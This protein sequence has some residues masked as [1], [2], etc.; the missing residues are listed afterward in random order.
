[1]AL[2]CAGTK[3]NPRLHGW[4]NS[5]RVSDVAWVV[6]TCVVIDILEADS[7]FGKSSAE[8]LESLLGDGLVICPVTMVELSPAF[9]GDLSAQKAFLNLCG[10]D[11]GQSFLLP[12]IEA[13]H[14]AWNQCIVSRRS[15]KTAKRPVADIMI[16]AFAQRFQGLVTRNAIDFMPWFPLLVIVEP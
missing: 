5:E 16:G 2:G 14:S 8:K 7:R 6:D 10:F 13:A 11:Y 9:G 1:M 4:L 15:G 12:D 3:V